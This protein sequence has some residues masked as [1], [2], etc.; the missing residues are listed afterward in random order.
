MLAM[1]IADAWGFVKPQE[2]SPDSELTMMG[3]V[4]EE[5]TMGVKLLTNMDPQLCL[6]L[7]WRAAQ[8]RGYALTPLSDTTR[9]FTASKGNMIVGVLA[10]SLAPHCVFKIGVESYPDAN[11]L[12]LE[13]NSPWLSGAS[14]VRKVK[15][16]AE[17]LIDAI[18][19]AVEKEGGKITERKEF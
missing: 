5:P 1:H 13:M 2:C 16:A 19:S 14:G 3:L 4:D 6:K 17:E 10:G 12:V 18:V 11:E 7:A 9:R 8:D 15:Q